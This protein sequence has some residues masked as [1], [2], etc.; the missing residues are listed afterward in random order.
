MPNTSLARRTAE[1][2]AEWRDVTA[3]RLVADTDPAWRADW[4]QRKDALLAE[5]GRQRPD[6]CACPPGDTLAM[7]RRHGKEHTMTPTEMID[8]LEA[9]RVDVYSAIAAELRLMEEQREER[10]EFIRQNI[11]GGQE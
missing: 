6:D 10:F 1:L 8:R 5:E 9:S 4:Q 7:C 11:L 3:G 2:L